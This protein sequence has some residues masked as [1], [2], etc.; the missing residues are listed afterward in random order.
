MP[1]PLA[2]VEVMGGR[3]NPQMAHTIVPGTIRSVPALAEPDIFRSLVLLPGVSQPNDMR[4]ALHLAGG[5]SDETQVTLDGHPLQR[6]FHLVGLTSSFNVASLDHA[7]VRIHHLPTAIGGAL[8][9]VIQLESAADVAAPSSELAAS[10]VAA[11]ATTRRDLGF[12]DLLVS[13]RVTYLD[14]LALHGDS[15]TV[16]R[17][18]PLY[19]Y[20][21]GTITLRRNW[22]HWVAQLTAFGRQDNFSERS[23]RDREGYEPMRDREWLTGL[24]V[25]RNG[26]RHGVELR[27][28]IN[29]AT[30]TLNETAV[31]RSTAINNV[32][33]RIS[34]AAEWTGRMERGSATI[35]AQHEIHRYTYFWNA[36]GLADEVFTRNAPTRYAS[37]DDLAVTS[38]YGSVSPYIRGGWNFEAGTRVTA[39]AGRA[40]LEPR[41]HAGYRISPNL[42]ASIA[43]NRRLQYTTA[44]EEAPEGSLS[45]PTFL[46]ERPRIADVGALTVS[47]HDE[48]DA[49]DPRHVEASAFYKRYRDRTWLATSSVDT[50]V[51]FD[52]V[53]GR[54]AGLILSGRTLIRG[55]GALSGTYT[56]QRVEEDLGD[57]AYPSSW[58]APHSLTLFGALPLGE[59]WRISAVYQGHSGRATTPVRA[60]IFAPRVGQSNDQ[61][62]PRY[63]LGRYNSIRVPP[64]HRLDVGGQW[65]WRAA[66][67]QWALSLQILNV[68]ASA[69]AI[70]YDWDQYYALRRT[71]TL[72]DP[73]KRS[74]LPFLPSIGLE[75]RW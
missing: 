1:I 7:E 42:R 18:I 37:D 24:R 56:Y 62:A 55:G 48:P 23:L 25:R 67:A 19:G 47:W 46:L 30:A 51:D 57:S 11:S 60:R 28:S 54:A 72:E 61:A 17:A 40:M 75:V 52:R 69:N 71:S 15:L 50:V 10:L 35:G 74:G 41:L 5:S 44:L 73:G 68:L 33:T 3:R 29:R 43:A 59:K 36:P 45:A 12:V 4:G 66:G 38:A 63:L 31:G 16:L 20:A 65:R 34:T 26:D 70:D 2:S 13:G 8:S 32:Q 27:A 14:K 64:Y 21:D 49:A 58:D 6:P 22:N 53:T 9:G 39:V